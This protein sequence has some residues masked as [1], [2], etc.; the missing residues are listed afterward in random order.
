M[1]DTP[2]TQ[3]HMLIA[4]ARIAAYAAHVRDTLDAKGPQNERLKELFLKPYAPDIDEVTE[5]M[6]H[7]PTLSELGL[8]LSSV[9]MTPDQATQ[10]SRNL[11][12]MIQAIF[13]SP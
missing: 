5:I 10:I 2:N 13:A 8:M 1:T 12:N 3:A 9:E 6:G 4:G 7:Q 11:G